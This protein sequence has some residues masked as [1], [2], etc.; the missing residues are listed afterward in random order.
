MINEIKG[1]LLTAK[2][3]ILHG[4][5]GRLLDASMPEP[6]TGCWFWVMSLSSEGYGRI[7][8]NNNVEY[9]HRV[10]YKTF[11]GPIPD[12]LD[13]DHVC[14]NRSCICPQHLEPVTRQVNL[15]R[16]V[17][18]SAKNASKTHCPKGHPYDELN[19]TFRRGSRECKKCVKARES[20]YRSSDAYREK[21]RNKYA[22]NKIHDKRN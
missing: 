6:N 22:K 12:E 18:V 10:S 19:T 9:A 14:R 5:A 21:M 17:G 4:V 3:T 7:S 1:D 2:G 13:I 8:V 20:L 16:G 15:L 11:V